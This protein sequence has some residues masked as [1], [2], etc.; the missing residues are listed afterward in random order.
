MWIK[1]MLA[2]F[3]FLLTSNICGSK[4]NKNSNIES[5]NLPNID[6]FNRL[7]IEHGDKT[8]GPAVKTAVFTG[9][10]VLSPCSLSSALL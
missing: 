4:E 9:P 7:D 2:A 3:L 5:E 8:S 10:L 1:L 6:V